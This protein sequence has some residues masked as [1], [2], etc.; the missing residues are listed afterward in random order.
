M[1]CPESGQLLRRGG[2]NGIR[3]RDIGLRGTR[4]R[5]EVVSMSDSWDEFGWRSGS[6]SGGGRRGL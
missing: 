6:G 1:L 3:R 5:N 4:E 2:L